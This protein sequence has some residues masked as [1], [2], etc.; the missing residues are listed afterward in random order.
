MKPLL[1]SALRRIAGTS[2][3]PTRRSVRTSH[4]RDDSDLWWTRRANGPHRRSQ[5]D[6]VGDGARIVTAS[7][8]SP[9]GSRSLALDCLTRPDRRRQRLSP[10]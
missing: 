1:A 5:R 8:D 3:A 9:R 2:S 10:A 7:G 4:G 6:G